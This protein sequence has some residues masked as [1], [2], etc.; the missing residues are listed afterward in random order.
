[1]LRTSLVSE[2]RRDYSL[3]HHILDTATFLV[4][5]GD[6][7]VDGTFEL[8]WESGWNNGA[9]FKLIAASQ[10]TTIG[11]PINQLPATKLCGLVV[12]GNLNVT[13]ALINHDSNSGATLIVQGNLAA[14]Q[15]SCGGAYIRIGRNATIADVLFAHYNDGELHIGGALFAKALIKDDHFVSIAANP[16]LEPQNKLQIIDLR[17]I[18][19]GDDDEHVPKALKKVTGNPALGLS[20][21]LEALRKCQSTTSLGKPQT[22]QDWK[23]V[24]WHDLHAL[25]KLPQSLRTEEMYL[26]LLARD[27][28]L[29]EPEIHEL[30]SKIPLNILSDRVRMAA[31]LLSP[32][33]LLRLPSEFDL[34]IEYARCLSELANPES[35]LSEIPAHFLSTDRQS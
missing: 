11:K 19:N 30:V 34:K 27:C 20:H 13:G 15:A 10:G 5:E 28:T 29:P 35:Y 6:L 17:E 23:N 33:S 4:Y 26:S 9:I 8:D 22:S 16:K 1:M 18:H 2:I 14:R 24:I 31:F 21:I 7:H 25:R 3:P 32:K 12:T